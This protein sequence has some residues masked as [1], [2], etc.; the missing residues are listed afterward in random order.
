[1]GQDIGGDPKFTIA[2]RI[3]G[4]KLD[5]A[6]ADEALG[7]LVFGA[8]RKGDCEDWS[9]LVPPAKGQSDAISDM[10]RQTRTMGKAPLGAAVAEAVKLASTGA[11]DRVTLVTDGADSCGIDACAKLDALPDQARLT[12]DVIDLGAPPEERDSLICLAEQSGGIYQRHEETALYA[13]GPD[14]APTAE[15]SLSRR[16]SVLISSGTDDP[17]EWS[18]V[19]LDRQS[20]EAMAAPEAV[21]GDF[22]TS[23]EP[24]RWEVHGAAHAF[25]FQGVITVTPADHGKT[26][27]IPA[28]LETEGMAD[29]LEASGGQISNEEMLQPEGGFAIRNQSRLTLSFSDPATGL[30]FALPP[31]WA[32]DQPIQEDGGPIWLGFYATA[33]PDSFP[34]IALNPIQWIGGPC[35]QIA[36]GD[37]CHDSSPEALAAFETIRHSI[38]VA[39]K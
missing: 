23:L 34:N 19:P 7:L 33:V 37:L 26:F 3:I 4:E 25:D 30:G 24:G 21:T 10:L 29:D 16:V 35:V 11:I 6:E 5:A 9:L 31:S 8:R 1:M 13:S 20:V 36:A 15:P 18:A 17:V 2:A 38:T 22:E 12:V 27:V 39:G 32:I 28:T 14:N